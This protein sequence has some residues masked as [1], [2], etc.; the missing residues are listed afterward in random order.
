[1]ENLLIILAV[2]AVAMF[3]V[4]PL[5]EKTAKPIDPNDEAQQKSL[6]QKAKII[7][8]LMMFMVLASAIKYFFV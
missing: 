7:R 1:M 3:I 6:M 8:F 4:V 2:L 5:V